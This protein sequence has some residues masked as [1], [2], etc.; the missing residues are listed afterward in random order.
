[1]RSTSLPPPTCPTS[2]EGVRVADLMN[3]N[4]VS[5]R[6]GATIG[7]AVLF[8]DRSG[9]GAA[10]VVNDAGRAVGVLSQFDV[11]LAVNAGLAGAPA[12]EVMTPSVVA[13]RP[14]TPALDALDHMVRHMVRR[15][16]VVDDGGVPVGVVSLSDLCR[17]L[18]A[19]WAAP[20][21]RPEPSHPEEY[22]P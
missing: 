19:R 17:G 13:V 11:L 12:R 16:F 7:E 5:I 6:H 3:P 8:L 2:L 4:P 1:M 18:A 21:D 10:P 15:V 14:H 22:V 20:E 9:F